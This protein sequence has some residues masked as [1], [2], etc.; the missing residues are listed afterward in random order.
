MCVCEREREREKERERDR[1][2]RQCQGVSRS[3]FTLHSLFLL[4][5]GWEALVWPF[6]GNFIY[7]SHTLLQPEIFSLLK[8]NWAE[9]ILLK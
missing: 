4:A 9:F 5:Y 2:K 6:G 1:E 7:F 8:E 3:V